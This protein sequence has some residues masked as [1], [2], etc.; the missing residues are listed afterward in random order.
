[1][2]ELKGKYNKDCKIFIDDVEPD[3]IAL[4][5]SILDQP[6]SEGVQIRIMPDTHLGVGTV[7]GMT[8][9]LT[10]LLNVAFVGC[11]IGCGVAAAKFNKNIKIDLELL[12][13]QIRENVP[14]GFNLHSSAVV[15][16]L[17]FDKIQEIADSF[18][19]KYN[20][21]FGTSFVAPT[22]SEKWLS[23]KLKDI[24]MDESKFWN[25]I[26]TMGSNNHFVELGRDSNEDYWITVHTGSRNLGLKIFDYWMGIANGKVKMANPEYN[27]ELDNI[28][29]TTV[30][31][32]LIPSKIKELKD[33]YKVGIDKQYLSDENLIGYIFDMILG[34]YF[35]HINR[36]TIL[37]IIKKLLNLDKYDDMISTVHN[38]IDMKDMM[39]RKGAVAS[40]QGQRFLLP[41]NMRDGILILDGKS[42]EEWNFSSPHG[43]GRLFSRS[44]AK[45]VVDLKEY[46]KSMKGIVTTSV[47]K[48]TLDESPMSYKKSELIESL[49]QDTAV[50]IDRIKPL[51][52]IK[53]T[54]KSESFKERK[55]NKKKRDLDRDSER[56]MKRNN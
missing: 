49:I 44:K 19:V 17:D 47:S 38:Y 24:N 37:N 5:Q 51:L 56:R 15:T 31:K 55:A 40:Y 16:K 7:I 41:F 12:E 45:S 1:M 25:S 28:L 20:K 10:E 33:K 52:N 14:T 9:P 26:G 2:I 29:L 21:K 8:M 48:E 22:Y 4:I 30:P 46:K 3:A 53:D 43:S 32:S 18:I 23:K 11:D 36:Q 13:S 42:N 27:K 50:V 6:V 39:I 35:A 54:G 34:Q